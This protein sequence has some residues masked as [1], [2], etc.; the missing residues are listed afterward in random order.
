VLVAP[1]PDELKPL[2][3]KQW[4][5]GVPRLVQT[6]MVESFENAG[7]AH[8]GKAMDGFTPEV[9]LLLEIRSFDIYLV[10]PH[11]ARIE[12]SAKW[13][14]PDAKISAECSF[15]ATAPATGVES[16]AAAAALNDAFQTVARDIVV[17]AQATM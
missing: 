3:E 4:A 12:I 2:E 16:S 8:V 11:S 15:S 1:S 7:F 6:K 14:G 10:A 9:Q 17:W 5:D 13:L